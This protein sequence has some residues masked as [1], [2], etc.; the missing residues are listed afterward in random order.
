MNGS[1]IKNA[2]TVA[3][4]ICA[5]GLTASVLIQYERQNTFLKIEY[6]SNAHNTA[7]NQKKI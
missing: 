1:D 2:F 4:M 7:D 3:T 5:A 6:P